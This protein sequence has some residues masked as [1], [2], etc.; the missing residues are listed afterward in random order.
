MNEQLRRQIMAEVAEFAT[1]PR[2][3]K[4]E[5]TVTQYAEENDVPQNTAR[6]QLDGAVEEGRLDSRWVIH[7]GNRCKAYSLVD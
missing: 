4:H 5:F 3:E 2:L 7:E 6:R 1:P